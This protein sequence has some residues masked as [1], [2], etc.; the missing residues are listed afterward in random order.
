MGINNAGTESNNFSFVFD[1]GHEKFSRLEFA[2]NR[3]F[4]YFI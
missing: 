3:S 2:G 1:T 4:Q